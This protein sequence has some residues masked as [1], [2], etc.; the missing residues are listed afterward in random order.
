[1]ES[2]SINLTYSNKKEEI[3]I[4][5][6]SSTPK[7]SKQKNIILS[8]KGNIN[9]FIKAFYS[10]Q[11]NKNI[12]QLNTNQK[13]NYLN[14]N[15]NLSLPILPLSL[16]KSNIKNNNPFI[17]YNTTRKNSSL[18]KSPKFFTE[19]KNLSNQKIKLNFGENNPKSFL[20]KK[21]KYMSSEEIELE[22]IKKEK[23]ESKKLLEK[24]K[25][26][27]YKSFIYTPMKIIPAP[28]TTFKPFNLSCNKNSKYLKEGKSCT[29]F[30]TNKLNQKIRLKMQQK[31]EA[32]N[33]SKIKN[34]IFLNNTDYLR[35]QNILYN[36]LF[37]VPKSVN[38]D[39]LNKENNI[40]NCN[41]NSNKKKIGNCLDENK[42]I[43]IIRNCITPQKKGIYLNTFTSQVKQYNEK[44]YFGKS[45]II[46]YYLTNAKKNNN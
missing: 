46:N 35:K 27:Y 22:K 32:L 2:K 10:I 19:S 20:N 17:P 37:K 39:D 11:K 45:K 4:N 1:M 25:K 38:K 40:N 6:I 13:N 5:S 28:L 36:D 7:C 26:T 44:N 8:I 29:L 24:N 34:E 30:E 41:I 18:S 33:D 42:D 16:S 12:N 15:E 43:N 23:A 14:K 21:R 3:K 9:P 31:I